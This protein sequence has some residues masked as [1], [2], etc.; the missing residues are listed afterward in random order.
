MY[1]LSCVF[2]VLYGELVVTYITLEV[3]LISAPIVELNGVT[4]SAGGVSPGV[5]VCLH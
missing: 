2:G 4:C 1:T 3:T 5:S